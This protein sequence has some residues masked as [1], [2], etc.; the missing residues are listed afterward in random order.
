M[1]KVGS[2]EFF[3]VFSI[4]IEEEIV[5]QNNQSHILMLSESRSESFFQEEMA[6]M[7]APSIL[8]VN[9]NIPLL[10]SAPQANE[11]LNMVKY[12]V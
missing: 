4:I 11:D 6:L 1:T 5:A 12:K 7:E 10:E 2:E 8:V 3:F 9:D